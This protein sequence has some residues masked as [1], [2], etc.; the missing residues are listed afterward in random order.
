MAEPVDWRKEKKNVRA[1]VHKTEVMHASGGDTPQFRRQH[2]IT[3]VHLGKVEE[4]F[5]NK[6][7]LRKLYARMDAIRP[8]QTFQQGA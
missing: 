4:H 7:W 5:G 3:L 1:A 2:V 6:R 8:A